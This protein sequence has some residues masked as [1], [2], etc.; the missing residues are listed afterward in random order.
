LKVNET[1]IS[2]KDVTLEAG[3]RQNVTFTVSKN[4][5]GDYT[6]DVN[7]KTAK[8]TVNVPVIEKTPEISHLAIQSIAPPTMTNSSAQLEVPP[9]PTPQKK[10]TI[11]LLWPT[12]GVIAA[13]LVTLGLITW[14]QRKYS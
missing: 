13:A 14:R 2:S 6:I 4:A 7:S 5:S 12:I 3:S 8:F 10:P 11:P 9:T 1:V